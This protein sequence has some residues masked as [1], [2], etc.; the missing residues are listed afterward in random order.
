[1]KSV[2][3]RG[4]YISLVCHPEPVEGCFASIHIHIP[5]KSPFAKG[6]LGFVIHTADNGAPGEEILE[7]LFVAT[8]RHN[9]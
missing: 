8:A 2:G 9:K 1:M 4:V 5:P 6:G 7:F 3:L